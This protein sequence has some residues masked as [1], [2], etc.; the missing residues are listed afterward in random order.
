M[1]RRIVSGVTSEA[2]S[3]SALAPI[4]SE[5]ASERC[6]KDLPGLKGGGPFDSYP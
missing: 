6:Y 4:A 3:A 1:Q 2:T 5:P